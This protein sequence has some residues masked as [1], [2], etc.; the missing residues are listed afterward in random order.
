V[1][2]RR[3]MKTLKNLLILDIGYI[4]RKINVNINPR[5]VHIYKAKMQNISAL[6]LSS[7]GLPNMQP[8]V[9]V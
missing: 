8:A 7:P 1:K 9:K 6:G 3:E 5:L 2:A 4:N